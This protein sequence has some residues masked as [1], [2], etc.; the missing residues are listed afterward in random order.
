VQIQHRSVNGQK[1]GGDPTPAGL[2]FYARTGVQPLGPAHLAIG[3]HHDNRFTLAVQADP[4]K[5]HRH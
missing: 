3:S 1:S 4:Q 5:P 2:D